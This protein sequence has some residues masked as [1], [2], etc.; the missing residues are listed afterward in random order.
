MLLIYMLTGFIVS[1]A[2]VPFITTFAA[3]AHIVDVPNERKIHIDNTPL[4]GGLGIFIAYCVIIFF[5]DS[6]S[7]K[8]YAMI[9]ANLL[10]IVTGIIDDIHDLRAYQKLILQLAATTVIIVFTDF[11]FSIMS[12]NIPFLS[13]P[14]ANVLF[15][16]A[17]V[18]LVT[19]ALNLIDGMDGLAGGIAFMAFGAMGY[20]AY[21]KGYELN[22]YICMGLMGATL[23]FLRYNIPPAKVFMGDTGSL[24]LGFNIAIMSIATSHKSGTLLSVLIP[25]MFISLP[26]FDTFLAIMRRALKGQNLMAADKEHLHHRLLSL[27]FS[28]VQ[29]LMIFYSL[30]LVLIAVS[31]LSL[32]KQFIWGAIIIFLVLYSFFLILKLFHLF[33]AGT[34]IRNINENMRQTALRISKY[35]NDK[36]IQTKW[37]DIVI[38]ITTSVMILNFIFTHVLTDY[39]QFIIAILFLLSILVTLTYKRVSNIKNQFVSFSF[40]WLF[41]YMLMTAYYNGFSQLHIICISILGVCVVLKIFLQK[42]LDL[43]IS[44]PMELIMCFCL[45]QIYLFSEVK[46]VDFFAITLSAFII[47]Y[48]NKFFFTEKSRLNYTYT[49]VLTSFLILLSVISFTNILYSHDSPIS[50][51]PVHVKAELKKYARNEEFKAGRQLLVCYEKKA[52]LS[53]MKK[54]YQ[55]EGAKIYSNL[56]LDSLLAGNLQQSNEYLREFLTM[57]PDLVEDFYATV[58]PILS[59]LTKINIT[60]AKDVRIA[61][62]NIDQITGAYASTLYAMASKFEHKGYDVRSHSYAQTAML[63]ENIKTK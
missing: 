8:M 36:T 53:L 23:G 38:A 24:F 54:I 39:Y 44:N 1:L 46:A 13:N 4:L 15:T 30:S 5:I 50:M 26:L 42:R 34:K 25:V 21:V 49:G 59:K 60:G 62:Y 33:D 11:R 28:S 40:F 12:L 63:L 7:T 3:K 18:V 20:A 2:T 31:L 48:S 41:F 51:T 16:Y 6:F 45:L 19:N 29:T 58:E 32:R 56:V 9:G 47:Y 14:F 57:F 43:F 61:G 22:A 52:P 35:N 10:I 17:W 55:A 37:L 27:E